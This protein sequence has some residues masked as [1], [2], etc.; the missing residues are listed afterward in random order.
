VEIYLGRFSADYSTVESWAPVT[1]NSLGDS[2]PDAWID[3]EGSTL[4]P[5]PAGPMGPEHVRAAKAG[6]VST[7]GSDAGRLLLNV[8][9]TRAGQVPTPQ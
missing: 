9:L 5:R 1:A 6:G 8:Q 2:H 3:V 4:P 7:G